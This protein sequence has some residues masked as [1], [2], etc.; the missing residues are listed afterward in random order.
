MHDLTQPTKWIRTNLTK[1]GAVLLEAE[2]D[3]RLRRVRLIVPNGV[4]VAVSL[5]ER[6]AD[7]GHGRVYNWPELEGAQTALV[8]YL[9]GEQHLAAILSQSSP[10]GLAPRCSVIV[11]YPSSSHPE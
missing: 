11:E 9:R 4:I 6:P 2:P 8:F 5:N 3:A 1:T 7:I 10:A